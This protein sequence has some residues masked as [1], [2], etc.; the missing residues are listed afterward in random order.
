MAC[1]YLLNLAAIAPEAGRARD[2]PNPLCRIHACIHYTHLLPVGSGTYG[3]ECV[4]I[5]V[6]VL[7][8]P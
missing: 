2:L 6:P 8:I 3:P 4:P 5:R 1:L 7:A